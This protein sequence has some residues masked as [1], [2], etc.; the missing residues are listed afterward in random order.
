MKHAE[1]NDWRLSETA[2]LKASAAA[3]KASN[4]WFSLCDTY[5]PLTS[6]STFWRFNRQGRPGEPTQGWKLHISATVLQ[7]C[8]LFEKAAPFLVSRGVRFKAPGSL[9]DLID[10]NSGLTYGYWQVGKFITVYPSTEREAVSL[11]RELH[12]LTAEFIPVAVPFD[13]RYAPR[14]SV[15]Y[16]YGAFTEINITNENGMKLPAL[17]NP[18]GDLVYDDRC[19][20]VPY[21]LSD[22]FQSNKKPIENSGK[23]PETPLTTTYKVLSAITQR[24]KGGT[25]LAADF[26]TDQPRACIIKEGRRHGETFW[27]GQ[28][29][30][31]LVRYEQRVLGS[32]RNIYDGVPRVFSSFESDGNFY[33]VMEYV[34]VRSLHDLIKFRRRRLPVKQILA[35]AQEIVGI[36]GKIHEAGWV[37]NDCKP[38]NL[39]VTASGLLR[40]I[41]FENAVPINETAPFNWKSL[42][43]SMPEK[44]LYSSETNDLYSF[45]AVIYL[46]LTGRPY[47]RRRPVTVEKLRRNVPGQMKEIIND[48]LGNPSSPGKMTAAAIRKQLQEC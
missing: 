18:D 8:D 26:S 30:Y 7:A 6:E 16:R 24:G 2:R 39:I 14:S 1:K 34:G 40:P 44:N 48:L 15:F 29:G 47:D 22:P 28:D 4:R 38:A 35:Y 25:Y 33:L 42:E 45:A 32:L 31:D 27:N 46:L 20:A 9:R 37:W 12:E 43:F 17:K 11:A 10:I 36:L 13:E 21:W 23:T 5:L 3:K 41:D 19:R